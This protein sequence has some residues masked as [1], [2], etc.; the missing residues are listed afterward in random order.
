MEWDIKS[1][2]VYCADSKYDRYLGDDDLEI[3]ESWICAFRGE[4]LYYLIRYGIS[5]CEDWEPEEEDRFRHFK[6]DDNKIL[7]SNII[8]HT[9][10]GMHFEAG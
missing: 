7:G 5:G 10:S 8:K 4:N 3:C 2:S 9:I 1:L 6:R